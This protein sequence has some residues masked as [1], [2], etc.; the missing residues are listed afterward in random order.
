M[1]L[2]KQPLVQRIIARIAS[3]F[4]Q[5]LPLSELHFACYDHFMPMAYRKFPARD[6]T[7]AFALCA[8]LSHAALATGAEP[9][10][11]VQVDPAPCLAA[12]ASGGDDDKVI[13]SCGPLIDN[14][15]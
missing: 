2:W 9:A 1:S 4:R 5:N 10:K 7:V 13:A 6:L 15:K 3:C 11:D 12:A 8:A 14:E